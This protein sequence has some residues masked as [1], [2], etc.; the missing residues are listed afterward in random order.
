MNPKGYPVAV[1]TFTSLLAGRSQDLSWERMPL[2]LLAA[3]AGFILADAILAYLVGAGTGAALLSPPPALGDARVR[4]A[5]HRLRIERAVAFDPQP[6]VVLAPR[7][8]LQHRLQE[9]LHLA[10]QTA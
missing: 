10:T 3:F 2:L 6:V 4:P 9:A 7:L 8:A 1:A 5:V